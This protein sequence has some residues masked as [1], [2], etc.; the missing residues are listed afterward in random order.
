MPEPTPPK[1]IA[2][3]DGALLFLMRLTEHLHPHDRSA[4]L[5]TLAH[6]LRGQELGDGLVF[7]VARETLRRFFKPPKIEGPDLISPE[8]LAR[9][10][11]AAPILED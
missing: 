8:R 10:K 7:R 6:E 4:F 1:P 11:A 2:L 3:S 9:Q 5:K